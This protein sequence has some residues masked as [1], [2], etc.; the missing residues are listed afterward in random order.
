MRH[1][2]QE[3]E[4]IEIGFEVSPMAEGVE[5]TLPFTI[6]V[7]VFHQACGGVAWLGLSAGHKC[8]YRIKD[9]GADVLDSEVT[10]LQ[11]GP[12]RVLNAVSQAGCHRGRHEN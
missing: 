7:F 8:V 9:A 1:G 6:S 12:Q 3:T 11:R 4:G 2:L 5:H 10:P